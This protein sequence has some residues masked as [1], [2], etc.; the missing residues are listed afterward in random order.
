MFDDMIY[1]IAF[2]L[3]GLVYVII[4]FLIYNSKQ[5][6]N[7]TRN[8]LYKL[9]IID[10]II[11]CASESLYC[12]L[13]TKNINIFVT[14]LHRI[15]LFSLVAWALLAYLYT[16]S[17]ICKNK[18]KTN[19]IKELVEL[20]NLNKF[21]LLLYLLIGVFYVLFVSK[22]NYENFHFF[23]IFFD[24]TNDSL[25]YVGIICTIIIYLTYLICGMR[26]L[27]HKNDLP[28]KEFKSI[29]YIPIIAIIALI[30]QIIWAKY[31][32]ATS[33]GYVIII[34]TLYFIY[35]NPDVE[36]LS[37]LGNENLSI[38]KSAHTKMDFLSNMTYEVAT[39]ISSIN[40][41]IRE[42]YD[43]SNSNPELVKQD[44]KMVIE[45]CNKLLDSIDSIL[46]ISK[47]ESGKETLTEKEYKIN[48]I[49]NNLLNVAKKRIGNKQVKFEAFIDYNVS[50]ILY[51]DSS[52]LYQALVNLI[53]NA[54][55]YTDVGKISFYLD[56]TKQNDYE[57]LTFKIAD[58]GRGIKDEEKDN[59]FTKNDDNNH[60]SSG[61]GLLV[62]KEY[63]D[64]LGGNIWFES[65][66]QVGST[67]YIQVSQKIVDKTPLSLTIEKVK[68]KNTDE[69]IDCSKYRALIVDDNKLNIKVAKRL[70]E[71]YKFNI[72]SVTGGNECIYKIKEEEHYDIIFLDHMMP[73]MDGIQTLHIL[74]HLDG[75]TL[76]PIIAL[77]ANAIA[78]MKEMYLNE[79]FDDYLAKPINLN[80]LDRVINKYFKK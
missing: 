47:I 59:V 26:A 80:E 34:F 31:I 1:S 68:E 43:V 54:I 71:G 51:G 61:L 12:L 2:T 13:L 36:I 38:D 37:E 66:Y 64:L 4:E 8:K 29:I 55:K 77:T 19:S 14:I 74:K 44:V 72:D 65:H 22:L 69:K 40:S 5:E 56:S 53:T 3:C 41:L 60:S 67:F 58:T 25:D 73:D 23:P 49:I 78:G 33:F 6:F 75:Y 35:E 16:Y 79:G 30:P 45:S 9:L 57:Q 28:S 48:D 7:K 17:I 50:S 39:P 18:L 63:I 15:N 32:A 21:V 62:T 24:K 11:I 42:I 76:P 20:S 70:L 46:D 52:R 27:K 10:T